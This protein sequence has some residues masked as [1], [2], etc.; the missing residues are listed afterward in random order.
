MKTWGFCG[1]PSSEQCSM[2]HHEVLVCSDLWESLRHG[3]PV[4]QGQRLSLR[5]LGVP[6]TRCHIF[7]SGLFEKGGGW[8][9]SCGQNALKI[10]HERHT[11]IVL[12]VFV[13]YAMWCV[14]SSRYNDAMIF[15]QCAQVS[16]LYQLY[17]LWMWKNSRAGHT[18]VA[19]KKTRSMSGRGFQAPLP[20]LWLEGWP[21][22]CAME[23]VFW[24]ASFGCFSRFLGLE[25]TSIHKLVRHFGDSQFWR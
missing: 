13:L 11:N 16:K 23:G 5:S 20:A 25:V 4:E 1:H 14:T 3:V 19:Q 12:F 6:K 8:D 22:G 18:W 7:G 24:L 2:C 21:R 10:N 15:N 17:H 9:N